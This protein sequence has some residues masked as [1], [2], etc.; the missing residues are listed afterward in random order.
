MVQQLGGD[1]DR[2]QGEQGPCTEDGGDQGRRG[3]RVVGSRAG[4]LIRPCLAWGASRDMGIC[5]SVFMI[6]VSG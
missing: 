4:I 1:S 5:Y 3:W 2:E 6:H